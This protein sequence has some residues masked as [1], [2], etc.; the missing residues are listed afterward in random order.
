MLSVYLQ[1]V[2]WACAISVSTDCGLGPWCHHGHRLW[3]GPVLS[4]W[5]QIV[6]SAL[7]VSVP[8]DG[9]P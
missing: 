7:A 8:T 9:A 6:D 1:I 2:E 5:L 4:E 3:I